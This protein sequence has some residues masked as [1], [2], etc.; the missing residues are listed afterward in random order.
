MYKDDYRRGG[1]K[2][3]S[4]VDESGK[5][6]FRHIILETLL[7]IL[8]SI[9]PYG[10]GLAGEAY[11]ITALIAGFVMLWL[12][13]RLQRSGTRVDARKLFLFSLI[14]L[15]LVLIVMAVDKRVF[16]M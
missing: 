7:L 16:F 5:T 15:P 14:Y 13:L 3:L 1:F 12:G 10:Y 11:L 9:F 6:C 8:V 2:M 4:L